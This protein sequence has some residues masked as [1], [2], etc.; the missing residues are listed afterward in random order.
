MFQAAVP[1]M[2]EHASSTDEFLKQALEKRM[3]DARK[4]R[5]VAALVGLGQA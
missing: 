2:L 4:M 1:E 5:K 3:S